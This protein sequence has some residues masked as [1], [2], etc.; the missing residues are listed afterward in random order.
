[1][2]RMRLIDADALLENYNLKNA[3]KYGNKNAEQQYNSYNTMMMYEIA[4][5]IEDAP[6]GEPNQWIPCGERLP[7]KDG[8]YIIRI[9]KIIREIEFDNIRTAY[10]CNKFKAFQIYDNEYCDWLVA[11]DVIYWQY[12]PQPYTQ[13]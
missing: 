3:T 8:E 6:T 9:V 5:M 10:F 12:L 2:E 13:N 11:E 7:D 4:D 1:M